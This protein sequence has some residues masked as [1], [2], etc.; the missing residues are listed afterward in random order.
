MLRTTL[1]FTLLF[2]AVAAAQT[3]QP[4]Y[5]IVIRNGKVIDGS[6]TPWFYADVAISEGKIAKIGDLRNA[7]SKLLID[8]Q[9]RVVAPG[10]I[11][12]HTH[13]DDDLYKLPQAENFIRDGVTTI[14]TGNCG[15]SV[16]DVAQY[17]ENLR[18]RGVAVNVGT[19]YGHNTI[20]R[21]VKGDKAGDLT[22]EQMTRA[23]E[24]LDK[25]MRDGAVG[26]STGLIYTPGK[27]S[28][29]EEIVELAKVAGKHRG[30]YASH[31]RSEGAGIIGAIDEALRIGREGGCRVQI[32]HFKLP[33]DY[34]AKVGGTDATLS[35]V[36]AAREAGQEVWLDQYPYTASSTSISTLLPDWLLENGADEARKLLA[37]DDG[38]ARVLADMKDTYEVRRGRTS[39]AYVVI[40]NAKNFPE[41]VGKNLRQIATMRKLGS[42]G[43]LLRDAAADD[44]D[45]VTMED[46]YRAALEIWSNGGASCVFHSMDEGNV[47]GILRHPL[48]GVASDSGVREWNAGQP[49]PRG[50]G[51]N[52]RVLG[53]YVRERK[54]ISLEDAVRKM[55][56]MPAAAFRLSDRGRLIEG[57]AA[58][59]VVFDPASVTD[60]STFEQPHAYSEGFDAVI[61]NGEVVFRDGKM[62][63]TLPGRPVYG[64]GFDRP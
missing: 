62:T 53:R 20:L 54:L 12:V 41:Y 43:E 64:P 13:A 3:T 9:G 17:F 21:A 15:G 33:T 50:Y 36:T 4:T 23:R 5:D 7:A 34:S 58:D 49:H 24:L 38:M 27:W 60:K 35:R 52:A 57:F 1:F 59:V 39:M 30:I 37:T 31:M 25:A 51:T 44:G 2:G 55:T 61:V 28:S 8:A 46:Q 42:A 18:K 63:G 47:E 26:L 16:R 10:F 48:V 14:I 19:L 56:G 6:G 40:A 32:S 45:E 22:P 29:T 11:D